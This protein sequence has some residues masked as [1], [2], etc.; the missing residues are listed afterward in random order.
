MK[1]SDIPQQIRQQLFSEYADATLAQ[2]IRRADV[3]NP[4]SVPNVLFRLLIKEVPAHDF[5]EIL[6]KEGN[7]SLE[8]AK[9]IAL[10]IKER[11]LETERR[12]LFRWGI[13]ISDIKV[14]DASPLDELEPEKIEE[15]EEKN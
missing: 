12:S 13:D 14:H 5:V 11:I 15:R 10:S 9:S 2:I 1:I 3:Q 6:S 8:R 4:S 7:L